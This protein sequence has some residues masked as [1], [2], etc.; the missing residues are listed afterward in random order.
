MIEKKPHKYRDMLPFE[1]EELFS[2]FIVENWSYSSVNTF[3]RNEKV[4]EMQY[5]YR[6]YGKLSASSIAGQAYHEALKNYF[7]STREEERI[8]VIAMHEIA[9]EYI[10]SRPAD[11]WKLQ[12]ST[13]TIDKCIETANKISIS[14]VNNFFKELNVYLDEIHEILDV[15]VKAFEFV[16]INGVDIPL[17]CSARLDLVIKT[18]KGKVVVI[19]HKSKKSFTDEKDLKLVAGK[20]AITYA[21]AYEEKTSLRVDEVWIVENKY[22]KNRDKSTQFNKFKILLDKDTRKLYEALLYEPLKRMIEAV[23]DPEHV[24]LINDNDNLCDKAELFEYWMQTMIGEVDGF[25]IPDDKKEIISNRVRKIR[26]SSLKN[27]SPKVIKEFQNNAAQFIQYDLTN[28]NMTDSEK[29]EYTLRNFAKICKVEHEFNGFSSNTFLVS[30]SPGITLNSIFKHRLDIANALGVSNVRI[31]K[32][33]I[34]YEDKS[35]LSIE[36]AAKNNDTLLFNE[37]HLDGQK[38]PIGMDNFQNVIYWDL[39][40]P[41][42]PHMLICGATGSGKSVSIISTVEYAIPAGVDE[43]IIFDPKFEFAGIYNDN[44]KIEIHSDIEDIEAMMALLVEEMNNRVKNNISK[45]TLIVFDEFA[46]AVANSRKG[47]ELKVYEYQQ[48]GNYANGTPKSKKIHVDTLNSLEENLRILLQKGRSV[49]FRIIAATQR[50]STKVITGDAKV[51]FPVQICFRVPKETDSRV[52]IDEPGAE[53]LTGNGDGLIKS[54][55]YLNVV[56]FQGFFKK[57]D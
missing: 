17:P 10:I 23:Q 22:S 16:K 32:D 3:S 46:D 1:L 30:L 51:N 54:P 41:T 43:I 39:N 5:I 26:D 2:N 45:K 34:V 29:I 8:D 18:K 49:G 44:S 14:L 4:F 52:V 15:E 27:V 35:Y 24:Y 12:K 31:N 36:S 13:P 56:R 28:K 21:I 50:A 57:V 48:V 53:A 20:Q 19:D 55:E 25:D 47:S 42:T 33:L 7:L 9:Y 6:Q 11:K 37:K 38:I 40:N